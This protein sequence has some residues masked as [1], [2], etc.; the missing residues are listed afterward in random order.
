MKKIFTP[1][2]FFLSILLSC[3]LNNGKKLSEDEIKDLKKSHDDS[4]TVVLDSLFKQNIY[5]PPFYDKAMFDSLATA[6]FY[7]LAKSTKGDIKLLVNS[8]IIAREIIEIIK[9]YS[10]DGADI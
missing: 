4:V 5:V 1:F 3:N 7:E 2:I 8:K 6:Q 9:T 10:E